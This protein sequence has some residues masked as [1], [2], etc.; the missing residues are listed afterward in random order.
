MALISRAVVYVAGV[1]TFKNQFRCENLEPKRAFM[2][3]RSIATYV[4]LNNR[5]ILPV[6]KF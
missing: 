5:T 6:V 2:R 4:Y 3:L 1:K